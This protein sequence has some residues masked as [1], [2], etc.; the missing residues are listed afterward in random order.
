MA[1][2]S[3]HTNPTTPQNGKA[4]PTL[5]R[6]GGKPKTAF[7]PRNIR[8]HD[9]MTTQSKGGEALGGDHKSALDSLSGQ[10]V[11]PGQVKSTPGFG[12]A[13]LRQDGN[14]LAKPPQLKRLAEVKP[15]FGMR[16][17]TSPANTDIG[18]AVLGQALANSSAHDRQ[19]L[20]QR[21]PQSVDEN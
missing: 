8:P 20:A 9:G 13:G 6:D 17:R 18:R 1:I 15:A 5:G 7:D 14:P 10:A 16:S 3:W 21:L 11:V 2:K 19:A 12:N 4:K